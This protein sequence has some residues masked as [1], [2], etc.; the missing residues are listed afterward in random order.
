MKK[1][2]VALA[3][4]TA[5]GFCSSAALA[6]NREGAVNITPVIGGY[7]FDGIQGI[8]AS[9]LVGLKAGYNLTD[10]IGLE[11][12]FHYVR[13]TEYGLTKGN[14]DNLDVYNYRL[15]AL[16]SMF[17]KSSFVPHLA[18]GYGGIRY[19]SNTGYG[20]FDTGVLSYGLGAKYFLNDTIA[21]RG[22]L[23]QLVIDRGPTVYNY[24]YTLGL[25]FQ[26]GGVSKAAKPVEVAAAPKK[27]AAAPAPAPAPA[28]KVVEPAPKVVEPVPPAPVAVAPKQAPAV[29]PVPVV[30]PAPAPT[31]TLAANPASVEKSSSSTLN[32]S[33]QN[34]SECS[35]LPGIGPVKPVGSMVV[36]PANSTTYKLACKGNGGVAES[37]ATVNV[38]QPPLDS[39]NDGVTDEFDKCP[40]TPKGT[41]VDK[42]GCP[43][44]ECKSVTLSITFETNSA[45]IKERHH[46]ELN[47]V[48]EKLAK[49]PKS[50][51]VIEGHTDNVGSA[52]ANKKLSQKRADSVKKYLVSVKGID[53]KRIAAKGFG[54]T[55]P[56]DSN[57]TEDGRRNNRR[58]EAVFSCPE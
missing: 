46:D 45:E 54:D 7:H 1:S 32:W 47:I 27:A 8:D 55:K 34:S 17:P 18:V 16:Y 49:F 21:L 36:S 51:T 31:A 28:P 20:Y 24:E 33:A 12:L 57:K 48:A 2:L 22:D 38:V 58:V 39:D 37:S 15:E 6:E 14:G 56:I 52:G 25:N 23:R 50:T 10:R 42:D 11:G 3:A 41:K 13:T 29:V 26:F 43:V 19:S 44:I 9:V 40:N 4:L 53:G 30:V 35:I 5:V